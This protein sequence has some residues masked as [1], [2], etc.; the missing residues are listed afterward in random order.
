MSQNDAVIAILAITVYKAPF[1]RDTLLMRAQGIHELS[2][3]RDSTVPVY[4]AIT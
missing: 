1:I 3:T 2:D 4:S